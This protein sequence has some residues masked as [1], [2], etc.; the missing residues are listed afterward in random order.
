MMLYH[1]RALLRTG[2]A[3]SLCLSLSSACAQQVDLT[4][5][6]LEPGAIAPAITQTLPDQGVTTAL[7]PDAAESAAALN[8]GNQWLANRVGGVPVMHVTNPTR[9]RYFVPMGSAL[10]LASAEAVLP[11]AGVTFDP[12]CP[13]QNVTACGQQ[14][15]IGYG[16]VGWTNEASLTPSGSASVICTSSGNW[17]VTASSCPVSGITSPPPAPHC[18]VGGYKGDYGYNSGSV[19]VPEFAYTINPGAE[20][21]CSNGAGFAAVAPLPPLASA[22]W[23]MTSIN[24]TPLNACEALCQSHGATF[25]SLMANSFC[26]Y[27]KPDGSCSAVPIKKTCSSGPDCGLPTGGD[28]EIKCG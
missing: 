15:A 21:S 23:S 3:L 9:A 28:A 18:T 22:S 11:G 4:A 7:V 27:W 13:A 24:P 20:I 6:E 10:E 17:L 1:P 16:Q 2:A 14:V 26:S 5:S 19:H 25:C 8:G 12:G